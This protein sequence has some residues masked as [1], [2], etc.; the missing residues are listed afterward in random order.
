MS[1][2]GLV[3]LRR[4]E[5]TGHTALHDSIREAKLY[6]NNL[7]QVPNQRI[8]MKDIYLQNQTSFSVV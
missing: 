5:D 2:S 8:M 7:I 6:S 4:A 3:A 1:Q